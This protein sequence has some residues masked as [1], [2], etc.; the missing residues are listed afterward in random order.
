MTIGRGASA[1]TIVRNK[2]V[3]M[4]TAATM[5]SL[6]GIL[7]ILGLSAASAQESPTTITRGEHQCQKAL[8]RGLAGYANGTGACLAECETEPGRR[9]SVS[10]PDT[11][12]GNCL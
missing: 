2:E 11:I 7:A 5:L 6:V 4:R 8:A 10:F 3:H 12:T 9:C 1:P